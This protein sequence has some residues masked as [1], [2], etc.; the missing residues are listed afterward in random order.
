MITEKDV[1]G[2]EHTEP[3]TFADCM[4]KY[5]PEL[6]HVDF[7]PH[8][9][10]KHWKNL[11]TTN[12]NKSKIFLRGGVG[13]VMSMALYAVFVFCAKIFATITNFIWGLW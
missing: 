6:I 3:D 4:Q 8:E 12:M 5:H 1:Y 13:A 7:N 11:N 9:F 2:Q 10:E